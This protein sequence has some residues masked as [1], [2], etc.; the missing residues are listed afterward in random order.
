[1]DSKDVFNGQTAAQTTEQQSSVR[2]EGAVSSIRAEGAVS[3]VR[4]TVSTEQR[5]NWLRCSIKQF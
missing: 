2:T 3:N 1:M 4:T 5:L